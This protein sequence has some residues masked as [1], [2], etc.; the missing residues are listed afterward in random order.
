MFSCKLILKYDQVTGNEY[1]INLIL[2]AEVDFK[3]VC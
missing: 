3:S 1:G 2:L